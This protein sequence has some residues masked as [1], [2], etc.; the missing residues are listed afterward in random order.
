MPPRTLERVCEALRE[1]GVSDRLLEVP[2][3]T[4]LGIAT[5]ASSLGLLFAADL[6]SRPLT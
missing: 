5:H 3:Y 6:V 1:L 4:A 2:R